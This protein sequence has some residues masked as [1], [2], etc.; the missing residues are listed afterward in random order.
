MIQINLFFPLLIKSLRGAVQ[1]ER[2]MWLLNCHLDF[3][4]LIN[5][6]HQELPL[7]PLNFEYKKFYELISLDKT[8]KIPHP[9]VIC[10]HRTHY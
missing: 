9:I 6:N 10:L 5:P 4:L 2:R 3:L 8:H 7:R 1:K